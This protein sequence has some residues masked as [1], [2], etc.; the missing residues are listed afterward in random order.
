L[1]RVVGLLAIVVAAIG[2]D[3]G[4]RGRTGYDAALRVDN[5]T[6]VEG[7]LTTD[8]SGGTAGGPAV[9]LSQFNSRV[10]PGAQSKLA[11][12]VELG[13]VS[14]AIGLA[15]DVAYW[16]LPTP[17][18]NQELVGGAV[19]LFSTTLSYSRDLAAGPHTLIMRALLPGGGFGPPA[20][21]VLTVA[22]DD[23]PTGP[24]VVTLKWNDN[25][26]LD[27]HVV[28]PNPPDS[29]KP[30]QTTEVWA[31]NPSSLPTRLV[32]EGGPYSDDELKAGGQLDMDSNGG[33]VIDGRDREHVVWGAAPPP[34][35]Y[36]ARVDAVSMCGEAGA[37][38]QLD[39][40]LNGQPVGTTVRGQ[41]TDADTR[42]PHAKGSGLLAL[43]WDIAPP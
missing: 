36:I 38:W 43:E 5:A 6:F 19:L 24:L 40:L 30:D 11:G 18:K 15:D 33:C 39:V 16:I 23:E 4:V 32:A 35:H 14:V 21:F 41:M 20:I 31:R 28:A 3:A 29:S 42:F 17:G 34:G 9:A 27:L 26:D 25:A 2:C 1:I 7:A 13:G 8:V 37:Q 22:A 10:L 12:S